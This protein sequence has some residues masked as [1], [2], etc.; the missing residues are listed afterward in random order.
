MPEPNGTGIRELGPEAE[1]R[2][3]EAILRWWDLNPDD[4][5]PESGR[6]HYRARLHREINT[7]AEGLLSLHG[8]EIGSLTW[9]YLVGAAAAQH[10]A[11]ERAE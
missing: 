8:I 5:P 2:V 11:Q 9:T 10:L 3:V 6:D 7:A 1:R 4:L